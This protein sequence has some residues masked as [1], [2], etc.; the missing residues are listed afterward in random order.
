MS[1]DKS[2]IS[3]AKNT[4][5]YR[6]YVSSSIVGGTE[7]RVREW[8]GQMCDSEGARPFLARKY[9]EGVAWSQNRW[10]SSCAS[11]ERSLDFAARKKFVTSIERPTPAGVTDDVLSR[12]CVTETTICSIETPL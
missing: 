5:F 4:K 9:R 11:P 10:T 12:P 3:S 8:G 6:R 7:M 1:L 2:V